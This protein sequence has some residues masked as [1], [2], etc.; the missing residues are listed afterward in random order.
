MLARNY[1]VSLS[2]ADVEMY[3]DRLEQSV[4]KSSQAGKMSNEELENIS[5]R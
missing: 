5:D 2:P 4:P 3:M 1:D